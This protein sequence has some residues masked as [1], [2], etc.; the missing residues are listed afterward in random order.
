MKGVSKSLI[1]WIACILMFGMALAGCGSG[2]TESGSGESGTGANRSETSGQ[3]N[4][5]GGAADGE[6][7]GNEDIDWANVEANIRFVWPGTSEI[8][9]EVA[10]KF[11]AK[12]K[13]KYPKINIEFMYMSWQDMQQKL[14]VMINSGDA[15]D[16]TQT[17][18]VT[19]LVLMNGLEDLT[20]YLERS[21]QFN[22]DSFLPGTLEYSIIDGKIYSIPT[23]GQVF[24]LMVNEQMLNE[25]GMTIDELKTWEDMERAAQLM[26]KE[27]KYGFGYPMGVA[28][29]AWR[30]PYTAA[31]SNDLLLSDTSEEAKGKYLELLQHFKNLQ[32]YMPQA[33]VT[34]GYPEMFRAFS[35][36]EVGM[37]AAGS[38]F[39]S[40]VYSINPEIMHVAKAIAY[41][42]GPSADAPKAPTSNVGYGMFAGSKNK[43]VAWKLI[44]EITSPEFNAEQS[45]TIHFSAIKGAVVENGRATMEKVYPKAVEDH[46]RLTKEYMEIANN[47]GVEMAKI[48]GQP[49]MEVVFQEHIVKFLT[50][51]AGLE[52]TYE[53]IR[54]DIDKI[55]AGLE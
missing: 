48:K 47:S 26:T 30:V 41:P 1:V 11:K 15:P 23:M 51:K 35:H 28:R 31:Y 25:A 34:W 55:K 27:G 36:G 6:T 38:Y 21:E 43:D 24:T 2:K 32:P 29:F 50:D 22:R 40:N 3:N 52:E 19:D 37:I 33:G 9:K 44:E 42:K 13:E 45:A 4:A 8:E 20:P 53:N 54:K 7:A 10:E 49:E 18:D 17:Q 39:N 12:M 46:I 14:A 5:Q 16:L